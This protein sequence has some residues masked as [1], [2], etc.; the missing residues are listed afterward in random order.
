MRY[1]AIISVETDQPWGPEEQREMIRC[2]TAALCPSE[3]EPR[4]P[5]PGRLL[6][7]GIRPV[8]AHTSEGKDG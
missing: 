7:I 4:F 3:E 8:D 6:S 2:L 1:E 5:P